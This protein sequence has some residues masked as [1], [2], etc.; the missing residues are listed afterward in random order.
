M[1]REEKIFEIANR[2]L[3]E[4]SS[5]S[6][7]QITNYFESHKEEILRDFY[8]CVQRLIQITRERQ[9]MCKK[10][11]IKYF[12]AAYLLSSTLT[13]T[14]DFQI[15]LLDE[16]Y[17]LDPME[18]CIYWKPAFLF[19]NLESDREEMVRAVD[20]EMIRVHSYELD[21]AWRCYVSE[22]YYVLAGLFFAE[23][24]KPAALAGGINELS[25][26]EEVQFVYGGLMDRALQFEL[27]KKEAGV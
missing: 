13:G 21:M 3:K 9:S 4:R 23:Y 18:S 8:Q 26:M 17:Y 2:V 20:R 7:G 11:P 25:L 16:Q 5:V 19:I 14:F 15:S 1:N 12:A 22:F 27:L 24:A 10:G 6:S